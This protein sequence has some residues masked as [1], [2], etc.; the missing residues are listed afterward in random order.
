[1]DLESADSIST[2]ELEEPITNPEYFEA[3]RVKRKAKAKKG[4]RRALITSKREQIPKMGTKDTQNG[5]LKGFVP[6][7]TTRHLAR[8]KS[9]SAGVGLTAASSHGNTVD[10]D[11]NF[12]MGGLENLDENGNEV[13]DQKYPNYAEIRAEAQGRKGY[14]VHVSECSCMLTVDSISYRL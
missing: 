10:S 11:T 8:S 13:A 9:A 7:V 3:P 1:L 2:V 14:Q 12:K 6:A 5:I 4:D